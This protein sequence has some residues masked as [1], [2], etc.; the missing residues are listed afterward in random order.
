MACE[1]ED[2]GG[3][4]G[5]GSDEV[6]AITLDDG[7]GAIRIDVRAFTRN[8]KSR[9]RAYALPRVGEYVMCIGKVMPDYSHPGRSGA[10]AIDDAR[11]KR[12]RILMKAYKVVAIEDPNREALWYA[13]TLRHF[14]LSAG[15]CQSSLPC[16]G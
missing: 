12:R 8:M 7:T 15:A 11:P 10:D 13:E 16:N 6:C 9:D 3:I 5:G 4:H 2:D 1:K 14:R